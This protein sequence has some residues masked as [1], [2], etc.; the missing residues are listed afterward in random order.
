TEGMQFDKG[1]ISPYFVTDHESQEAVLEDALILITNSKI[2]SIEELLPVLE[3][4]QPTGKPLLILA[5]DVEGQALATLVVNAARGTF[6]ALAVK[7]PAFGDRRKAMLEDIAVLTG[8]Q[9]VSEE[10]GLKLDQV[11][12]DHLGTARRVVAT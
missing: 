7:A 2:G 5:E 11:G 3:K 6:R 4:V 10:I 12:L 1:Y 8:G 9:L